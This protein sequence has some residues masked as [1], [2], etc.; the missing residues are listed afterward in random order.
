[1]E[2]EADEQ[3]HIMVETEITKAVAKME[4]ENTALRKEI[5]IGQINY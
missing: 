1:M 4:I 5:E 3:C 2:S